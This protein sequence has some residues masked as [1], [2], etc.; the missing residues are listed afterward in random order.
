MNGQPEV[1]NLRDKSKLAP[2][3][4]L[5]LQ[6][7]SCCPLCICVGLDFRRVTQSGAAAIEKKSMA[8]PFRFHAAGAALMTHDVSLMGGCD[9]IIKFLARVKDEESEKQENSL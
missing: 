1:K 3:G 9:V 4:T 2:R 6:N 8:S 7:F 5:R